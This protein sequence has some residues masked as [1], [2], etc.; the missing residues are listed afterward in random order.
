[1]NKTK[2]FATFYTLTMLMLCACVEDDFGYTAAEIKYETDFIKEFGKPMD[3]HRW[4]FDAADY[5]FGSGSQTRAVYKQDMNVGNTNLR[6]TIL[7]GKPQDI[8]QHEHDEV[9]AWFSNHKINWDESCTPTIYNGESTR[10]CDGIAYVKPENELLPWGSLATYSPATLGDYRI[11][12]ETRFFNGWIQHVACD[13]NKDEIAQSGQA[14]GS[15]S[16]MDYLSFRQLGTNDAWEHLNDFNA[17][18]GYGYGNQSG[19]NAI[20]VTD[21]DFNVVTY[22]CS[23]GSSKPHDKYY[24]VYLKG[25]DYEGWYL[26]MDFESNGTNGNE[27]VPADGVCNDWIIKIANAGQTVYNPCRIMCEDL[28]GSFDTDFNDIVY[29]VKYENQVC[30]I[31]MQAAGGTMPIQ[32]RYGNDVLKKGNLDEIHAIFGANVNQPVN[33]NAEGGVDK[34]AIIWKLGFQNRNE[35]GLDKTYSG[36]FDFQQIQVFV[37]PSGNAEWLNITLLDQSSTIPCRICV[38]QNTKWCRELQSIK[39]GYPGF[40]NWVKDASKPFWTSDKTI[41]QSYLH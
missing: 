1:M 3:G 32:L 26:G 17:G 27:I 13:E 21:V 23:A 30:T 18:T 14:Y 37:D 24:I 39:L 40:V 6:S 2:T 15:G 33:V 22:N 31:T 19:Q 35:N 9:F 5:V 8:T 4:G 20:L 7:Y 28:G 10:I 11:Q 41:N 25:D 29:D 12:V 38:P 34:S 16:N 36:E